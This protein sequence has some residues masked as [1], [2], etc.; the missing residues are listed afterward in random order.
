MATFRA[1]ADRTALDLFEHRLS[2]AARVESASP[3]QNIPFG[4]AA[5]SGMI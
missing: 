1:F 5:C 3:V 2:N 4:L